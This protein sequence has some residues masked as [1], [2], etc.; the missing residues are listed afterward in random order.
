MG[1]EKVSVADINVACA[2]ESSQR[3]NRVTQEIRYFRFAIIRNRI[4]NVITTSDT[5]GS[6]TY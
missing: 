3:I 6:T 2:N 1:S 4:T 5:V